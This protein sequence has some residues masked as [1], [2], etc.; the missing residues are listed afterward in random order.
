LQ[1]GH[2]FCTEDDIGLARGW[3]L[4]QGRC[5]WVVTKDATSAKSL[6]YPSTAKESCRGV[7]VTHSAPAD[8]M[9]IRRRLTE[10]DLGIKHTGQGLPNISAQVL[11]LPIKRARQRAPAPTLSRAKNKLR[12]SPDVRGFSG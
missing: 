6:Q 1:P 7:V 12:A 9:E 4:A 8:Y 11:L 10:L 3:F 2:D 5:P